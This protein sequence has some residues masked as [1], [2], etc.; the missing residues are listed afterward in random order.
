MKEM[1]LD[2]RNVGWVQL[3]TYEVRRNSEHL[4]AG[5]VSLC[6]QEQVSDSRR[7]RIVV[8]SQRIGQSVLAL[9]PSV[10]LTEKTPHGFPSG[11]PG[12][13]TMACLKGKMTEDRTARGLCPSAGAQ[14]ALDDAVR[15]RRQ[16][17]I[18][19]R[20]VG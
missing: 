14:A 19:C 6:G 9:R 16:V 5:W 12:R 3:K 1:E 4:I 20:R 7:Q 10:I 11:S 17:D 8:A 15:S 13:K 2:R 18:P